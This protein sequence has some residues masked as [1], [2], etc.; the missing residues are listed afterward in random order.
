[1]SSSS[2]PA[3]SRTSSA[4]PW[5]SRTRRTSSRTC[6]RRWRPSAAA[7]PRIPRLQNRPASLVR[8]GG[9]AFPERNS[10]HQVFPH[11]VAGRFSII[12]LDIPVGPAIHE[13][14]EEAELHNALCVFPGRQVQGVLPRSTLMLGSAPSSTSSSMSSQAALVFSRSGKPP[15]WCQITSASGGREMR[16]VHL[17]FHA[18]VR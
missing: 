12:V 4:C 7:K 3:C 15:P 1:M 9:F 16:L 5:V 10:I 6:S 18:P 11:T 8:P 14:A 13:R 17:V 2:P